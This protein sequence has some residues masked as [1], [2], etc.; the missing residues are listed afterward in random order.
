MTILVDRAMAAARAGRRTTIT[1]EPPEWAAL[2]H[3][4]RIAHSIAF[5]LEVPLCWV[6]VTD[7][8]GRFRTGRGRPAKDYVIVKE[9]GPGTGPWRFIPDLDR[10]QGWLMIERRRSGK[11]T[12]RVDALADIADWVVPAGRYWP[13]KVDLDPFT[14]HVDCTCENGAISAQTAI[15]NSVG[16]DWTAGGGQDLVGPG[17]LS[18]FTYQATINTVSYILTAYPTDDPEQRLDWWCGMRELGFLR[19]VG[20]HSSPRDAALWVFALADAS[21]YFWGEDTKTYPATRP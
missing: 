19:P 7:P 12:F 3:R 8:P 2:S 17:H 6:F 15:F 16:V 14:H 18:Q 20:L 13:E 10:G 5:V 4:D 9:P 11:V 21:D 1:T